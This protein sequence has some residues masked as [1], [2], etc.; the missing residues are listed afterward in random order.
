M[1]IEKKDAFIK[2]MAIFLG[3]RQYE[4]AYGLGREFAAKFPADM[5]SHYLLAKAAFWTG[6]YE[7]AL[8]EGRKA[9]NLASGPDINACAV[10]TASAY[11]SLGR[12]PEGY[13]LLSSIKTKG[14]EDLEK[15]KFIFA[16]VMGR[17][18]EAVECLDDLFRINR[19]AAEKLL[20]K[21]L[22]E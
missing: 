20:E 5:V 16:M 10:I 8:A 13:E 19:K 7:E 17:E 14:D 9:F 12:Y 11:Y 21:A 6:K 15:L 3:N 4:D 22:L 18:K 1:A 2:Q